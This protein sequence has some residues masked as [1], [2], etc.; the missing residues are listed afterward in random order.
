MISHDKMLEEMAEKIRK[1][2]GK[3]APDPERSLIATLLLTIDGDTR[4]IVQVDLIALR[5]T[6]PEELHDILDRWTTAVGYQ[7][8]QLPA[9][10]VF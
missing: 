4:T 5:N 7:M 8:T 10:K 1:S 9:K 6:P 2:G 3:V